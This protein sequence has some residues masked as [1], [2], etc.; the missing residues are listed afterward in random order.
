MATFGEPG[1]YR[2]EDLLNVDLHP[3]KGFY[4]PG[5]PATFSHKVKFSV[6]FRSLYS[7]DVRNLMMAGR[8]ISVSHAALGATRV[9]ITCGLQGQAV[10]TAAGVPGMLI[11]TAEID[12]PKTL[13]V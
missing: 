5:P 2:Q 1:Y 12:P 11:R 6:P 9:M 8:C 10:G 4:D 13:P 3:P 7:K